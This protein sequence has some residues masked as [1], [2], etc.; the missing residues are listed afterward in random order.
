[1]KVKASHNDMAEMPR[2]AQEVTV[3]FYTR[4][5]DDKPVDRKQRHKEVIELHK[6]PHLL[7]FGSTTIR[8]DAVREQWSA[9]C[10]RFT[11]GGSGTDVDKIAKLVVEMANQEV[12][13]CKWDTL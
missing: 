10:G 1:M 3:R 11:L 6:F 8:I 7:P 2:V 13:A 9:R 5:V 12:L 4:P